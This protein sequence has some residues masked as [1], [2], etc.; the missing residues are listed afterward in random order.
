MAA[1]SDVNDVKVLGHMLLLRLAQLAP[2]SV[3][4]RLDDT[5][6]PF[7]EVMRDLEVKEDTIRQDLERKRESSDM[8]RLRSADICA[9][10][11]QRSAL[12]TAVPLYKMSSPAQAPAFH[13]FVGGLLSMDQWK[14]YQ[15][16][17]A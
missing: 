17:Q 7:Q 13:Q 2:T 1:L 10:E 6:Q 8:I 11:M 14:S 9:E 3:I 4:P 5:V 16:Y 15:N 12:R